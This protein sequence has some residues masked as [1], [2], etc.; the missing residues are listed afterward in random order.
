M[1]VRFALPSDRAACVQLLKSSHSAAGFT[2]PFQ[3]AYAASLFDQHLASPQAVA[4]VLGDRPQGILL[5]A[6]CEHPFGAG[7]YAKETVWFID[8]SARGRS[9]LLMLDAY[10]RWAREQSCT[11][12]GMASLA[13]NDVSRLYERRGYKPA[14]THFLKSL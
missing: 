9:A 12:V 1:V 7:R 14:E 3:A 4:L 10:E 6:W 8:P 11:A 2:F 5:A 13:S